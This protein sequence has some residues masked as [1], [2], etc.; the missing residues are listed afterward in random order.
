MNKTHKTISISMKTYKLLESAKLDI[1]E[2]KR[3]SMSKAADLAIIE[4]V[5]SLL[6]KQEGLPR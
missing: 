2:Y 6:R 5:E 1:P 3:L 4:G